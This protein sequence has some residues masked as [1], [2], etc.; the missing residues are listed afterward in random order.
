MQQYMKFVKAKGLSDNLALPLGMQENLKRF[1]GRINP[2][3]MCLGLMPM[4]TA[5]GKESRLA[6]G[7]RMGER[8][9]RGILMAVLGPGEKGCDGISGKPWM[10]MSRWF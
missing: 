9:M 3:P 10:E 4:L 2:S 7:K 5:N 8:P 6:H 1:A